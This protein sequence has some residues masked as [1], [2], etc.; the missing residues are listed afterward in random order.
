[1]TARGAV[2]LLEHGSLRLLLP[3]GVDF[4]AL[5]ALANDPELGGITALLLADAGYA[6]S[7]PP[8]LLAHLNPQLGLLSAAVDD[9]DGLPDEAVIDA[10]EG[11]TLLRTDRNGWI[12]ITSDGDKLWV[13]AEMHFAG[14]AGG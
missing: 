12:E 9:F 8:E 4:E 3:L 2:L 1:M 10:L 13:E 14:G 5:E 7:N 11:R 6:P